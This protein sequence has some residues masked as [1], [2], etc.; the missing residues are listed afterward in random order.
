MFTTNASR[1]MRGTTTK[2]KP[3]S[4]VM[5]G[6]RC[7]ASVGCVGVTSVTFVASA[8]V[9]FNTVGVGVLVAAVA[10][11]LTVDLRVRRRVEVVVK[12]ETCELNLL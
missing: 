7:C 6:L 12:C 5:S 10:G 3:R 11:F 9:V 4:L 1:N 8:T 2:S